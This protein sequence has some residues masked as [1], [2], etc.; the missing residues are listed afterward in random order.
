MRAWYFL[1]VK[2]VL[3]YVNG[4]RFQKWFSN[5]SG[6]HKLWWPYRT[7]AHFQFDYKIVC[8]YT[9]IQELSPFNADKRSPIMQK[10][11]KITYIG[12]IVESG[13]T[14]LPPSIKILK[15]K[16]I[17]H[18][19]SWIYIQMYWYTYILWISLNHR[20]KHTISKVFHSIKM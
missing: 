16:K 14:N 17:S 19:I 3:Q 13:P 10:L 20:P 18:I 1:Y 8:F 6:I 4:D 5:I 12:N 15:I 11:G 7:F 9:F 2:H